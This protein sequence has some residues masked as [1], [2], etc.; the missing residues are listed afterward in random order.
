MGASTGEPMIDA[1]SAG[2]SEAIDILK[3]EK[4]QLGTL[5]VKDDALGE[6]FDAVAPAVKGG[7]ET[8]VP[9]GSSVEVFEVP[10]GCTDEIGGCSEPIEGNPNGTDDT[11]GVT[12]RSYS[13]TVEFK[14]VVG[15][16]DEPIRGEITGEG[17]DRG[18][19][20]RRAR[21]D[22]ALTHD[23]ISGA[24]GCDNS[25][26]GRFYGAGA[27]FEPRETVGVGVP[28]MDPNA[29]VS[30]DAIVSSAENFLKVVSGDIGKLETDGGAK[31]GG[32]ADG[33]IATGVG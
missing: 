26:A 17:D 16:G 30:A 32:S 18:F 21:R 29:G 9:G 19:L 25:S 8:I 33:G 27:H 28:R 23:G 1:A 13:G 6:D 5:S 3:V 10:F 2:K 20:A 22:G 7:G 11:V 4:D 15:A 12:R 24:V 14:G 31:G